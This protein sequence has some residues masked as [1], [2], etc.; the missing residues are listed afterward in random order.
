MA[1]NKD[2]LGQQLYDAANSFNNQDIA[3]E[4]LEQSRKDFWKAVAETIINHITSSAQVT[5][6]VTTVG[7]STT[8][9]GQGT[10]TIA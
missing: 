5:V 1:L 7:S 6:N 9:T 3:P 8:Q 2:A 10:G 4:Q